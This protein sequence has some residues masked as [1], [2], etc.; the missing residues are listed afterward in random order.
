MDNSEYFAIPEDEYTG[1]SRHREREFSNLRYIIEK[2]IKDNTLGK[3]EYSKKL[4]MHFIDM[5]HD[6][7]TDDLILYAI[8]EAMKN[9]GDNSIKETSKDTLEQAR[10]VYRGNLKKHDDDRLLSKYESINSVNTNKRIVA[11][12]LIIGIIIAI[13]CFLIIC[14]VIKIPGG[15]IIGITLLSIDLLMVGIITYN[16]WA[17]MRRRTSMH[18]KYVF[19]KNEGSLP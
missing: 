7:D 16:C 1:G 18:K 19:I 13:L 9:E 5:P 14:N 4:I 11:S 6:G 8:E 3:S 10:Q 12:V 2:Q 17:S 15:V